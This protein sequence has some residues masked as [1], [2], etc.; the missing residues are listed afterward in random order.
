[1]G[2]SIGFDGPF[3]CTEEMVNLDT[4]NSTFDYSSTTGDV[5]ADRLNISDSLTTTGSV[6]FG[7]LENVAEAWSVGGALIQGRREPAGAGTQAAGLAISG[8]TPSSTTT[9]EEYD[10]S[11]W[12]AGGT[13]SIARSD[14]GGAGTQN[15]ALAFGGNVPYISSTEEYDGSS[16]TSGGSLSTARYNLAGA[17]TQNAGLAI[18][19]NYALFGPPPEA[20]RKTEEYN[21]SSWSSGGDLINAVGKLAAA[22]TQNAALAFGGVN[23]TNSTVSCTEEYDGTSWATGGALI[24]AR[25]ELA[26][27]GTQTA[28][29]AFGGSPTLSC[30]EEFTGAGS[31]LTKTFD[32]SST[33]GKT[34]ILPPTTDPGVAGALWNNAGTLAISA[35]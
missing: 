23:S 3:I 9:S 7:Y 26:G 12:T 2:G 30:T 1:M 18:G 20:Q 32:Y 33:T 31:S 27:A 25:K 14:F 34:M 29:L 15:A 21:G 28:G 24:T 35:G 13:L 10:G 16:W 17:G 6:E 5:S 8:K 11:S 19:G 4:L 22:G